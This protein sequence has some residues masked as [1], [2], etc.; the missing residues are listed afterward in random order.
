MTESA[1]NE[2]KFSVLD[3]NILAA[4]CD[5]SL[6]IYNVDA[7][8]ADYHF[9]NTH[10]GS[11]KSLAFSPLNRLLLCSAGVDRSVSFYDLNEKVTVKKIKT[12]IS[13]SKVAFCSDG[14]TIAVASD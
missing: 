2:V 10:K 9:T 3:R 13:I 5:L 11:V 7:M 14:Y 1:C 12:D 4:A 8:R 6:S